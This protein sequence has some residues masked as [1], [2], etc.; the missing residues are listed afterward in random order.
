MKYI[1]IPLFTCLTTF[2]PVETKVYICGPT[3]AKKY[4]LTDNCRGLTACRHEITKV[5]I[6]QAQRYGLTLCGWED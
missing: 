2:Y 3:G 4:H 5:S 6:S 1:I